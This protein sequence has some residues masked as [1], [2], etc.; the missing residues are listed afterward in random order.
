M[1]D[2]APKTPQTGTLNE[3]PWREFDATVARH[4]PFTV[5]NVKIW[6]AFTQ[7]EVIDRTRDT[8]DRL[9][10]NLESG[11][12]S[13]RVPRDSTATRKQDLLHCRQEE[14]RTITL[15]R[16]RI[17]DL[18]QRVNEYTAAVHRHRQASQDADVIPEEHDRELWSALPKRR[19]GRP[20]ASSD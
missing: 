16:G 13:G 9:R 8:L 17:D 18:R 19:G 15:F 4:L 5:D 3:M 11:L 14:V 1:T 2:T 12:A 7:P 10:A 20:R 6:R